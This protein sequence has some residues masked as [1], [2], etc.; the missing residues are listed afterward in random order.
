MI[1]WASVLFPLTH[2]PIYS[3][4]VVSIDSDGV[5]EWRSAKRIALAGTFEKKVSIRSSG[6][7][8]SGLA[9]HLYFN[10]NPSKFL[11]GHNVFGSDDIVSL[12]SDCYFHI[13]DRYNLTPSDVDIMRVKNGDYPIKRVDINYSFTLPSQADVQAWL[14]GAEFKAKTRQGRPSNKSGSIYFGSTSE[15]YKIVLYSKLLEIQTKRGSL[16]LQLQD[17]GIEEWVSNVLRCEVR[18]LSKELKRLNITSV[19]QLTPPTVNYLFQEYIGRL[20]MTDQIQLSDDVLL[21]MPKK[22]RST[23]TL[24]SEG[25]DLRDMM[26]NA[27]Y[28]RH[29]NDLKAYGINIDLRPESTKKTN[30][31]PLVRVLE[32]KPAQIPEWAFAQSLVHH[33]ASNF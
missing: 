14:R 10:G 4:E 24:W 6:G 1:D 21:S 28:H 29:R 13:V 31:V 19:N 33:S 30:V 20:D 22:L 12:L 9:T 27:T 18:L 15:Y 7:N 25:H 3:G 2:T 32:A 5:E 17:R 8:G 26:S 16:P 23:Y 11:Q